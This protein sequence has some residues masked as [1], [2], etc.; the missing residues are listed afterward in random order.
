MDFFINGLK[1][2]DWMDPSIL[3]NVA[4]TFARSLAE[5]FRY[6][7]SQS[8]MGLHVH[9]DLKI[10]VRCHSNFSKREKSVQSLRPL[11]MHTYPWRSL[12]KRMCGFALTFILSAQHVMLQQ[13][14]SATLIDW[15]ESLFFINSVLRR[16]A[17]SEAFAA[18]G[19]LLDITFRQTELTMRN[20]R[21][22]GFLQNVITA[23][24]HFTIAMVQMK[25]QRLRCLF[26]VI[27]FGHFC[28]G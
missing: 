27:C 25:L 15:D 1:N 14:G 23:T 3:P 26:M 12:R 9:G 22:G 13:D 17:S 5:G 16:T 2:S 28:R 11:T 4:Y 21:Q 20:F 7:S 24:A 18:T 19:G 6:L 10:Q 8:P